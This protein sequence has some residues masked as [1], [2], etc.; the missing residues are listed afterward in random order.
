MQVGSVGS[1]PIMS[2][3]IYNTN[4]ISSKSMN[5]ISAISD[6]A[7]DSSTDIS[8]LTKD[9]SSNEVLNPLKRGE[10]LDFAG[11]LNMQMQ[12][13]K[14]NAQRIMTEPE[15]NQE[16]SASQAITPANPA[17][18]NAVIASQYQNAYVNPIQGFEATV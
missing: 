4:A 17:Q 1:S 9:S 14:M 10:S 15:A 18:S 12:M 11:I 13:G 7:L 2:P 3:Y 8:A 5:K 6:N 16:T